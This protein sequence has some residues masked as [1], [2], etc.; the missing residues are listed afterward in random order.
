MILYPEISKRSEQ[1][2][3][4][5]DSGVTLGLGV[6]QGIKEIMEFLGGASG[7]VTKVDGVVIEGIIL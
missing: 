1:G 4:F 3:G 6:T 7:R 5:R 2:Y